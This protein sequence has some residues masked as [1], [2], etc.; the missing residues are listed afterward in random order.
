MTTAHDLELGLDRLAEDIHVLLNAESEPALWRRFA[1]HARALAEM[2]ESQ[3]TVAGIPG[4]MNHDHT[5]DRTSPCTVCSGLGRLLRQPLGGETES[6]LREI[7][8]R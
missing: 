8:G 3:A 5:P 7:Y 6:E 4:A 2:A 1:R